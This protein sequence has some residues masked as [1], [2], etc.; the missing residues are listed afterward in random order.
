M[1][2]IK[3][4]N[5]FAQNSEPPVQSVKCDPKEYGAN[6]NIEFTIPK[7]TLYI[8]KFDLFKS[9][10][11]MNAVKNRYLTE[12]LADGSKA[13]FGIKKNPAD[14]R[15]IFTKIVEVRTQLNRETYQHEDTGS[16][17]KNGKFTV[18]LYE[19]DTDIEPGVYYYSVAAAVQKGDNANFVEVIPPTAFRIRKMMIHVSDLDPEESEAEANE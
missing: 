7:G 13:I 16:L 19:N 12:P 2:T 1:R 10:N 4:L 11:W 9:K 6:Q 5:D 8:L 3:I 17:R 14:D 18:E 15:Y